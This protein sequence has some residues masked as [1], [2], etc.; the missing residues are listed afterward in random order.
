MRIT[1]GLEAMLTMKETIASVPPLRSRHYTDFFGNFRLRNVPIAKYAHINPPLQRRSSLPLVLD[2][3][4]GVLW[5]QP[6]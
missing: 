4:Y 5:A 3:K 2:F 1:T 6:P